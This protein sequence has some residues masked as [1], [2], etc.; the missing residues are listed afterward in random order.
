MNGLTK[1]FMLMAGLTALLMMIG[2]AIGGSSGLIMALLFSC[3]GNLFAYFNS[4]KM[5]HRMTN[6]QLI[7][8]NDNPKLY[9]MVHNLANRAGLPNPKL[10]IINTQQPNA[11]ATGRNPEN[12]AVAITS[13]LLTTL[14]N[15][16]VAGVM[17]HELAHIKNRDTLIMTITATMAGAISGIA[18]ML[19]FSSMFR[20]NDS[21]GNRGNGLLQLL[22]MLLAPIAASLVQMC[23]SRTR[24]Y[25]ADKVGAEICGNPLALASALTHIEAIARGIVNV[26][27]EENPAIAHLFIINP[28][29]AHAVDSLFSTHPATKNRVARLQMMAQNNQYSQTENAAETNFVS[30]KRRNPWS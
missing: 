15:E 6:A 1:T 17:A 8:A 10:Y 23:I 2:N 5:L 26:R 7:E 11:F 14:N 12:A 16:E 4:D 18:N 28:L 27:A 25:S 13:G 24:E 30:R 29:H 22:L 3:A 9:N 20:G 19:M 21:E